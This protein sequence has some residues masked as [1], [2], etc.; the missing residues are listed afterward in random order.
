MSSSS[1]NVAF[2]YALLIFVWA[3]TPLA[4][5]WS[6]A[7]IH[8]FWALIFRFWFALPIALLIL[9]LFK[10]RLPLQA[11][12]WHSYLAGA[13][14]FIGSQTFIYAASEHT[15]SG[16]MALMFGFAP[17]MAGLIAFFVYGQKVRIYQWLGMLVSIAGLAWICLAG[18]SHQVKPFGILLM[19]IAVL[20]YAISIFWVKQVN[21]AVEPM[22]QATGSIFVSA[23]IGVL[24]SP[25]VWDAFPTTLP[26][27][28]S[29]LAIAYTVIM[30]SIVAMFC[31]FKLVQKI[32]AT[33]MSL[34][35][36]LTPILAM[37]LG[38]LLNQEALG[39]NVF[40]GSAVVLM[41]LLLYFYKDIQTLRMRD[42]L[43]KN[44]SS[45]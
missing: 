7:E 36:V 34:T 17:I 21:A 39:L 24:I 4:I 16:M 6:V 30:A 1:I 29:M 13:T 32:S 27:L 15:T 9:V 14:G 20:I 33:T 42:Q 43:S 37:L 25:F 18:D 22:A 3:S 5:V 45:K 2:T 8:P 41:G 12:A 23:L 11:K 10:I 26:S 19:L 31:Y 35:T 38:A 44:M 40:L 28:K